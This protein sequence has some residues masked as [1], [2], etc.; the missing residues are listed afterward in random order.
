MDRAAWLA[1]RQA[2]TRAEYDADAA[3]Y[4]GHD[5]PRDTQVAYVARVLE[6][7]PP[8]GLLLDAPCGTGRYFAQIRAAGRRIVGADQSAGML[9]EAEAKGLAEQLLRVALQD[10]E[11]EDAFDAVL[12]IDGME[13]VPPE[14]WPR[15]LAN[16]RRAALPGA[17]LYLT[18]EELA[19][20]GV[21]ADARSA[22][23]ASGVPAVAGEV[24]EG[25]VA[26][27]HFYP[28][29]DRVLAWIADAALTVVEE[30]FVAATDDWG[31]RHFLLRRPA[32]D[33]Q[34]LAT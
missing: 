26:A 16:L 14:H 5:Y 10:L 22:L 8:G 13:N 2:A 4:E 25:E 3:G 32:R 15:V 12:T 27:Y 1:E 18:V 30:R 31:Y 29:R 9:A 17:L 21:V 24:T 6:A 34:A 19:D 7:C 20:P 28:D 23:V 11:L 33:D